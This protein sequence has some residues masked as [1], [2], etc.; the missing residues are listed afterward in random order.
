MLPV[1]YKVFQ[2]GLERGSYSV[3][4]SEGAVTVCVVVTEAN[5]SEVF[6]TILTTRNITTQ[7]MYMLHE[8]NEFV[9]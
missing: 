5:V 8:Q 6:T 2:F 1:F 7:G 9:T 4:E 3:L